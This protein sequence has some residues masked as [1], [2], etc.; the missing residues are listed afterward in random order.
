MDIKTKLRTR[1]ELEQRNRDHVASWSWD[2]FNVAHRQ[3]RYEALKRK[4]APDFILK[5]YEEEIE[6]EFRK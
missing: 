5:R 4:G 2:G 6:R 3:E 1:D